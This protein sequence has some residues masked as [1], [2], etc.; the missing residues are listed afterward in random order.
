MFSNFYYF[1]VLLYCTRIDYSRLYYIIYYLFLSSP[2]G[3]PFHKPSVVLLDIFSLLHFSNLKKGQSIMGSYL[4]RKY[5]AI[6][7]VLTV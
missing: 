6:H 7:I 3:L 5:V 2:P 1:Y 4:Q